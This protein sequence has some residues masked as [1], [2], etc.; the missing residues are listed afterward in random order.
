[1]SERLWKPM[2][3]PFERLCRRK[4]K[5]KNLRKDKGKDEMPIRSHAINLLEN[6]Y[7]ISSVAY[8]GGDLNGVCCRR[9]LADGMKI[10][11]K[12]KEF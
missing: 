2:S 8:H 7:E 4:K 1:M 10:F 11:C 6:E 5:L 9:L 3:L 12:R